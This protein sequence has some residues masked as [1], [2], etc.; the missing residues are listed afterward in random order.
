MWNLIC[1]YK[2]WRHVA[3]SREGLY[4][5]AP[6]DKMTLFQEQTLTGTRTAIWATVR[7]GAVKNLT[8]GKRPVGTESVWS[9]RSLPTTSA[10]GILEWKRVRTVQGARV[11]RHG[12]SKPLADIGITRLTL[13]SASMCLRS[14]G[15]NQESILKQQAMSIR[16]ILRIPK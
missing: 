14:I 10:T 1:Q 8:K 2:E 15:E 13:L 12:R 6:V 16:S 4:G 11:N 3:R 7:L 9:P 5:R